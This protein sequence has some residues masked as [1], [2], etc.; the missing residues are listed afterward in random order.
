MAPTKELSRY[1]RYAFIL[2]LMVAV[3]SGF[4]YSKSNVLV[5]LVIGFVLVILGVLVGVL[6]ID[7]ESE[8]KFLVA[9]ITLL[10]SA[11]VG[12]QAINMMKPSTLD[13]IPGYAAVPV[14]I[15][16]GILVAPAA[17]VVA[18]RTIFRTIARA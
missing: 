18:L 5:N 16:I 3:L 14:I 12:L 10:A 1:S 4:V 6:D 2:G 8:T 13:I 15:Y 11:T 7:K 9:V 17:I